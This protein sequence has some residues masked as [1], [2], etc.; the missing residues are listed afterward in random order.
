MPAVSLALLAFATPLAPEPSSTLSDAEAERYLRLSMSRSFGRPIVAMMESRDPFSLDGTGKMVPERVRTKIERDERGR[1]RSTILRPL[2][3][4]GVT[5]LDDGRT[6]TIRL[7]DQKLFI[8]QASPALDDLPADERL[9]LVRRNYALKAFPGPETLDRPTV[10]LQA[11]PRRRGMETRRYLLD[12]ATGFPFRSEVVGGG[13][14]ETVFETM[15]VQF[16][17]RLSGRIFRPRSTKGYQVVRYETPAPPKPGEA[18]R[19]LGFEPG[20]PKGPPYGFHV[21]GT[22]MLEASRWKSVAVRLTDGLVKAVAYEWKTGPEDAAIADGAG[23]S[24]GRR[25]GCTVLLVAE[26]PAGIRAKL[27]DS[28]LDALP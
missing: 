13:S 5:I 11:S 23:R 20:I 18:L 28:I 16:P 15:M 12:A 17:E 3:L 1:V 7:P 6:M 10:L 27:L 9:A 4:Q 14:R 25:R 22:A 21:T 8:E 26:A 2:R 24:V 19:K